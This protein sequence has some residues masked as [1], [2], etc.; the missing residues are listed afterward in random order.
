[1]LEPARRRWAALTA[2]EQMELA[3]SVAQ[4]R[5]GEFTRHFRQVVSV[6]A[7][8]KRRN[9]EAGLEYLHNEACVVFIVRRKLSAAQLNGSPTQQ[10]PKE[11]LTPVRIEGRLQPVAVPTDVQSQ[12]RLLGARAQA[13]SAVRV[14]D[15]NA[16]FWS[17]GS[18]SWVL[19]VGTARYAMAPIH[20]LTP[21][22]D[23]NSVGRRPDGLAIPTVGPGSA[24]LARGKD[25]GGRITSG[26]GN[27]LDIQ[28]AAIESPAAFRQLFGALQLSAARPWVKSEHELDTRLAEGAQLEIHA[29]RNNEHRDSSVT[30]PLSAERS[31]KEHAVQLQYDFRDGSSRFI[32]HNALELQV[33]FGDCTFPGDSG[34]PVL[35]VNDNDFPSFAG[36]HIAG[37]TVAGTSYVIPAWRIVDRDC[38]AAAGGSLPAGDLK[39]P[40]RP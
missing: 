18:L 5:R 34:C 9:D 7:G 20:V 29:P 2:A 40:T 23:N 38:Y 17:R 39:I 10:L 4:C 14:E 32:T 27:S 8:L 1:M 15:A 37:N 11:L 6:A 25:F 3:G 33:R 35:L 26:P 30:L 13:L 21:R 19:Q 22:P 16:G 24:A 28:L 36:M 31:L 12:Q